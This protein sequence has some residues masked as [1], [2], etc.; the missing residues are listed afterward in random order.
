MKSQSKLHKRKDPDF[1][2]FPLSLK[3]F[4]DVW[5]VRSKYKDWCIK[6]L[7]SINDDEITGDDLIFQ[8]PDP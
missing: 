5:R 7:I 4:S 3:T 2:L 8:D 6:E 1:V